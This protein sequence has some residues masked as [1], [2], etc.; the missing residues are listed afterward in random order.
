M[1][2]PLLNPT[3]APQARDYKVPKNAHKAV[4][5]PRKRLRALA[6]AVEEAER[7]FEHALLGM[8]DFVQST[9]SGEAARRALQVVGSMKERMQVSPV[10]PVP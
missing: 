6:S 2:C 3:P 10:T 4:P 7:N 8:E 9:K 1:A 5:Q